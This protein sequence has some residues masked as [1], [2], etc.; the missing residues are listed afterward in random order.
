MTAVD[1]ITTEAYA[2]ERDIDAQAGGPGEGFFRIVTTPEQA[3]EVI[4]SGKMAVILG[5]E[6]S[7]LFECTLTPR[8]GFPTCDEDFIVQQLDAYYDRGIRVIFPVHK[9]DNLFSAGD[10]DR[11]FIEVGNVAATG[12]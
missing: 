1:R 10:G 12:H 4:A 6:T 3:R 2:M 8:E 7:H 5:I 11:A 9:Y